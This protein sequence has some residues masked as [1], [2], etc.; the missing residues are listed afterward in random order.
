MVRKHS[1]HDFP[2]CLDQQE[3]ICARGVKKIHCLNWPNTETCSKKGCVY[4]IANVFGEED[5]KHVRNANAETHPS[6]DKHEQLRSLVFVQLATW[7]PGWKDGRRGAVN[8]R[9]LS[10]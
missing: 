8:L 3:S 5:S 7:T 6:S 4:L 2:P 1:L 10:E 9:Y